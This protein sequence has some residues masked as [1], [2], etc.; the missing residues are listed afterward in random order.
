VAKVCCV[1]KLSARHSLSIGRD[2]TTKVTARLLNDGIREPLLPRAVVASVSA[3][4][5]SMRLPVTQNAPGDVPVCVAR[6]R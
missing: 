4:H 3:F 5:K 2:D 6:P 1:L